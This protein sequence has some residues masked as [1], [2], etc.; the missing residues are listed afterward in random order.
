M[1]FETEEGRNAA[2]I[3]Y[4]AMG[5]VTPVKNQGNCGSCWAFSAIAALETSYYLSQDTST[6]TLVSLSEQQLVDCAREEY[7]NYGCNG[8]NYDGAYVYLQEHE[9]V[10]ETD[11]PYTAVQ[12]TVC[13]FN[14]SDGVTSLE[15]F[16]EVKRRSSLA[17]SEALQYGAVAISVKAG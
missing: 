14:S 17:M 16:G 5:A 3:N 6:K 13:K 1:P 2:A 7:G 11:Y 15:L 12:D 8:G 4:V 9:S 10:K